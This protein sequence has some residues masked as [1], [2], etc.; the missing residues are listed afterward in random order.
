MTLAIIPARAGSKGIKGKNLALLDGKPLIFYS[1]DAAKKA[2]NID[3]IIV[4][5]DGDEILNF[6]LKMGVKALKRPAELALD[7]STSE[8]LILHALEHFKGFESLV[9]LQPTSPLRTAAHINAAFELY[10]N[11]NADALISVISM[12]NKAL[13]AFV[14]DENGLLRGICNDDYPFMPRQKLPPVYMGNG[15]IYIVKTKLFIKKPSFL[16]SKTCFYEMSEKDSIDIDKPEDLK[17]AERVMRE[18]NS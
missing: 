9:L 13:K 11:K 1:I 18:L 4:S 2:A 8:G 16:Q 12:D 17:E 15:A 7:N 3:E 6:A 5:S 14:A 10:K